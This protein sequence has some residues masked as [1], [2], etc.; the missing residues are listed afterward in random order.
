MT[1]DEAGARKAV[2][3]WCSFGAESHPIL[4]SG[5]LIGTRTKSKARQSLATK[6]PG[7]PVFPAEGFTPFTNTDLPR[8]FACSR[9]YKKVYKPFTGG[10]TNESKGPKPS[11][12]HS[13]SLAKRLVRAPGLERAARGHTADSG[14]RIIA[15]WGHRAI[16]E[17]NFDHGVG[18]DFHG[19]DSRSRPPRP[20]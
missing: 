12:C 7:T 14:G 15:R 9:V 2:K 13:I 17:R 20:P 3:E 5:C 6:V 1:S 18:R 10:F 8:D 11:L 16:R 4:D 19:S